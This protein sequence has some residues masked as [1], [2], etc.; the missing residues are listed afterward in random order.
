MSCFTT[1]VNI[2]P[3]QNNSICGNLIIKSKNRPKAVC[4]IIYWLEHILTKATILKHP[5][6][7]RQ[8]KTLHLL[9]EHQHPVFQEH[10]D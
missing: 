5:N 1:I 10:R 4:D 8:Y 9:T 6:I 3:P 2:Y 7:R